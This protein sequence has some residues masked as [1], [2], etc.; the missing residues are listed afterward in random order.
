MASSLTGDYDAVVQVSIPQIN[1]MLA[2]LHQ[3]GVDD[4]AKLKLPHSV[5]MR[6][7][8]P[9]T[10]PAGP[11][12]SFGDWV[13]AYE[14][15]EDVGLTRARSQLTSTA[16]PGARKMM[17]QAFADLTG[18]VKPPPIPQLPVRGL[19]KMQVAAPTLSVISGSSSQ[20]GLHVGI[21]AQYYPDPNTES[22]NA[23]DH[24]IHGEVQAVFDVQERTVLIHPPHLKF[25]RRLYVTASSQDSQI[26]FVPAAGTGLTALETG[27]ISAQVREAL[28]GDFATAPVDLPAGFPFSQ[29][30]AMTV[31][32][33]AALALPLSLS[34]TGPPG[35]GSIQSINELVIGNSGFA[36]GIGK[37]YI[38]SQFQPTLDNLKQ[39]TQTVTI[40]V[41]VLTDPTYLISI[42]SADVTFGQGFF[43]LTVHAKAHTDNFGWPS[44]DNIVV[45]QKLTLILFFNTLFIQAP[46]DQLSISGGPSIGSDTVRN[47]IIAARNQALPPAQDTLNQ[48][49]AQAL[50]GMKSALQSFD[51]GIVA[52]FSSGMST[53][54]NAITTGAVAIFADGVILRGEIGSNSARLA[55]I[56]SVGETDQHQSFTALESW[57]PAGGINQMTWSWVEYSGPSIFSGV[58]KSFTDAHRF[59]FPKPAGIT[60]ASSICLRLDGTQTR[61][62]GSV[63]ASTGGTTCQVSNS[64]GEIMLAPTWW[65]PV[66]VPQWKPDSKPDDVLEGMVTGHISMQSDHPQKESLT[67]NTLVYFPDWAKPNPFETLVRA[68]ELM[69][70]KHFSLVLLLVLPAKAFASRRREIEAKLGEV[71]K[72][73]ANRLVIT[74]DSE[75]GWARTFAIGKTPAAALINARREF[76]WQ[77]EGDPDPK[78]LAAVL[79]KMLVPAPAPQSRPLKLNVALGKTLSDFAFTDDQGASSA[80]HR[81]QGQNLLLNFWQSWSAPCLKEL[82]RLEQMQKSAGDDA[83]TIIAF[84]GGKDAK[85]L[86]TVRKK[87]DLTFQ[88]VQDT[89]QRIARLHGVRCWPTTISVDGA[90]RLSAAQF[91]MAH[92]HPPT[93]RGKETKS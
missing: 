23:S 59:I 2:T 46:D 45:K 1:G 57:T 48:K 8:D 14:A 29:F 49:L 3:A 30:K 73:F 9:P 88:L 61:S 40:S 62:A 92:D 90:G 33:Q 26:Q 67:H 13:H 19:V 55:P 64:Y 71:E 89:D 17:E 72:L 24:P 77:H 66:T 20:I 35:G 70:R 80:L 93:G 42:S 31:G 68:R 75:G 7:G 38:L 10:N 85:A 5:T 25:A 28:R 18:I 32:S 53:D 84:H 51:P 39:F 82:Q 54:A 44:Y 21:R 74:E 87:F 91:G 47:N 56:V 78:E 41:P 11:Q 86:E 34:Q 79:D 69:T 76:A 63:V 52:N 15:A 37:D 83:P 60:S 27:Q 22:L 12:G 50:A 43:E 65:E 36:V 4:N 6:I 16:P 58:T 81:L